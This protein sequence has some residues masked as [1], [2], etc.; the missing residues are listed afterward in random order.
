[1]GVASWLPSWVWVSFGSMLGIMGGVSHKCC[2]YDGSDAVSVSLLGQGEGEGRYHVPVAMVT[3]LCPGPWTCV[4]PSWGNREAQLR[5][6]SASLPHPSH[7]L[8]IPARK[9]SFLEEAILATRKNGR[10]EDRRPK[11]TSRSC[12]IS[13]RHWWSW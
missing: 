7:P 2:S 1:M 4:D 6:T 3:V 10:N 9:G 12:L 5:P 11:V 8:H 13:T